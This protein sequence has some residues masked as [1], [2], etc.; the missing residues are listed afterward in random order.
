MLSIPDTVLAGDTD[1]LREKL[2]TENR[3]ELS[4]AVNSRGSTYSWCAWS[5]WLLRR[6]LSVKMDS[7][8]IE[9]RL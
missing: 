7:E 2:A 9:K 5:S 1:L 8:V 4:A 3:R 6:L